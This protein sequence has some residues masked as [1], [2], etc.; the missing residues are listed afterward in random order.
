[1]TDYELFEKMTKARD[2]YY[3]HAGLLYELQKRN[4]RLIEQCENVEN[5]FYCC[6]MNTELNKILDSNMCKIRKRFVCNKTMLAN[7]IELQK[8]KKKD[9]QLY[10]D[11]YD[12]EKKLF[13][14]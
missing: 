13:K 6:I 10:E 2:T 3:K 14:R 11:W 12:L 5:K 7:D 4:R 8:E 9:C 1:M